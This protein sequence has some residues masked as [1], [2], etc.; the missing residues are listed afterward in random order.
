MSQPCRVGQPGTEPASGTAL[1]GLQQGPWTPVLQA[2]CAAEH[3]RQ[4]RPDTENQLQ[5]CW[6]LLAVAWEGIAPPSASWAGAPVPCGLQLRPCVVCPGGD[7]ARQTLL[8]RA[9]CTLG[10]AKPRLWAHSCCTYPPEL[11]PMAT[12][13]YPPLLGLL[14]DVPPA[15]Q[16]LPDHLHS[17]ALLKANLVLALAG[18]RLHS[19]VL[20][21]C[22]WRAK[23]ESRVI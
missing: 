2:A 21:L 7:C 9:V 11:V 3:S 23:W 19:D 5:M 12:L 17:D 18:V 8:A 13:Q 20:L 15:L 4:S 14:P 6:T 16:I 22:G 1:L 10:T